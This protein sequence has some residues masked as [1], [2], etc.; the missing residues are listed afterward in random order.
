M[1]RAIILAAGRGER[2]V[3]GHPYPKPLKHVHGIPLIV[4]VLRNLEA[5]GVDEVAIVVGYLGD[6]LVARLKDYS[7]DMK[8]RFVENNEWNKPNGTSLLKAASFV[9]GPTFLL[10]SDHLWSP[11]LLESV[12]RFPLGSR[13]SVLGVD[14]NISRCFDIDDATKVVVDDDRV[15]RIGKSLESYDALDTGVF[16]I[17]PALVEALQRVEDP[18]GC[19]LSQGVADLAAAGHMR[20]AD[21][22]NATWIDVD[23]PE[24]HARAEELISLYGSSLKTPMSQR[25]VTAASRN[26]V[27]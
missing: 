12:R 8:V 25:T 9:T 17:T 11:D 16:R 24:A 1:E 22:G 18:A 3:N 14:F 10:M 27:A 5:A 13:E 23:T 2:L 19:S 26:A 7:F 21:V 15:V 20:V 4:R 6:V